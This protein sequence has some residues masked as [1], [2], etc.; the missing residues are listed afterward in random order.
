[1]FLGKPVTPD[2][3]IYSLPSYCTARAGRVSEAVELMEEAL[4]SNVEAPSAN[5]PKYQHLTLSYNLARLHEANGDYIKA[6]G[7]YQV[8]MP[9]LVTHISVI[10]ILAID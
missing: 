1:M 5:A 2:I 8:R 6:K 3:H 7:G 4:K 10:V 9:S